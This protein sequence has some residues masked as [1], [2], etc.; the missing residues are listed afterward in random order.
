MQFGLR[1]MAFIASGHGSKKCQGTSCI[2]LLG[3]LHP[4]TANV[5]ILDSLHRIQ[6]GDLQYLTGLTGEYNGQT[7][8]SGCKMEL[9]S[10]RTE[11]QRQI[12]TSKLLVH[13]VM[14]WPT[15][16]IHQV[17]KATLPHP[18]SSSLKEAL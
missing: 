12:D 15:I 18:S 1:R 14:N 3:Q 6:Y 10:A 13:T 7:D 5:R 16:S 11:H 8:R 4:Q 9:S 2:N 17:R